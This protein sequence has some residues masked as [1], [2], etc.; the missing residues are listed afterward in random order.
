MGAARNMEVAAGWRECG[1]NKIFSKP[2]A[3]ANRLGMDESSGEQHTIGHTTSR[4]GIKFVSVYAGAQGRKMEP[5]IYF[6][7]SEVPRISRKRYPSHL[8]PGIV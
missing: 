6:V 3:K 4:L 1:V 8:S 7:L 2:R 5:V